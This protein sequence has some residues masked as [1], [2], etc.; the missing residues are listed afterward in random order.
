[1]LVDYGKAACVLSLAILATTLVTPSGGRRLIYI[2]MVAIRNLRV[3]YGHPNA[4]QTC[5]NV[6]NK[7]VKV[8]KGL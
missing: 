2:M 6:M 4:K 1:M 3:G 5:D 8:T 7:V